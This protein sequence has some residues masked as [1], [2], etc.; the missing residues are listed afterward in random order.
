MAD[1]W[2]F[3]RAHSMSVCL[4]LS[5]L[6]SLSYVLGI[7]ALAYPAF[8]VS[9]RGGQPFSTCHNLGFLALY[10]LGQ[11]GALFLPLVASWFGPVSILLPVYQAS[12]LLW[13]LM[14]MMYYSA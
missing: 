7:M 1:L 13:N 12:M 5:V 11:A 2:R 4:S 14:L 3:A 6:G 8:L 9:Q 10:A